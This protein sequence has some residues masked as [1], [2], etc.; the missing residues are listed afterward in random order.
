MKRLRSTTLAL[1]LAGVATA[2]GEAVYERGPCPF[3]GAE[4]VEGLECG[5]LTVRERRGLRGGRTLRLAVAVLRSTGADPAPDP[6]VFLSGGPGG[7]SVEGTPGRTR[8]AFWSRLRER[9]D[10][11]FFDQ[12][13]TGLSE[14]RFCPELDTAVAVAPYRNLTASEL[15]AEWVATAR[16]CRAEMEAAG[17]DLTA[18]T[19]AASARDLDD[20]RRALGYA[21]W[22]LLGVSYGTRLAL[23]AL[24]EAPAGIRAVILDSVLP[25]DAPSVFAVP[26]RPRDRTSRGCNPTTTTRSRCTSTRAR[27]KISAT[28]R[29][30][31]ATVGA[32]IAS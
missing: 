4:G 11:I 6:L 29:H 28:A 22:N 1:A 18:Y 10:L 19:S 7:R 2:Q 8:S 24:R 31:R 26:G 15:E 17:V 30:S 13:G 27:L 9:R 21:S 25:P 20:L 16:T 5:T 23:E 32:P 3:D 12:R 14:P